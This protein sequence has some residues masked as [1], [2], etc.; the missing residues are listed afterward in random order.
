MKRKWQWSVICDR[1]G[2]RYKM[3]QLKKEWTGLMVCDP[4]WE[5][6]QPQDLIKTP[7]D[8][9]KIPWSRPEPADE[10][11]DV[12]YVASDVGVQDNT[13]LSGNFTSNNE[14]L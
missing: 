5:T 7:K 4:C 10:F 1:C 11:I 8:D 9:G 3:W 13:V 14:T 2:F 12:T 6:R